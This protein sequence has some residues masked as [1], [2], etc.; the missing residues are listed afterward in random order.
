MLII[1]NQH[2]GSIGESTRLMMVNQH[3]GSI[4]ES[5]G[6]MMN[7]RGGSIDGDSKGR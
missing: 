3:S 5:T 4:D 2:S 1:L 7:Q 6:L